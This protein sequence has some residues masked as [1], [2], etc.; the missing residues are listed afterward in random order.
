MGR[1]THDLITAAAL[2]NNSFED[3]TRGLSDPAHA[4]IASP[5][6]SSADL[7][8][9]A[10]RDVFGAG[11]IAPVGRRAAMRI[12]AL[13]RARNLVVSSLAR[14]PLVVMEGDTRASVQPIWTT[15]VPTTS[16]QLRMAWTVD[17]VF[18]Y[19]LSC[20]QRLGDGSP[21]PRIRY[22]D[23]R[24]DEDGR[25]V[26]NDTPM[27]D[28][29]VIT[30]FGFNEG[31]LEHGRDAIS[32]ASML[33][34]AVRKRLLNPVPSIDL[35]QTGGDQ[36]TDTEIDALIDRWAAARQGRNGGVSY[37]NEVIDPREMGT[38]GEQLMIE[39][40]NAA[41]VDMARIANVSA[42]MVDATAP[43][44]SLNYETQEGRSLE[45]HDLDLALY[46]DPIT[47]RLSLDDITPPGTRTAFDFTTDTQVAY[48]PTGAPVAD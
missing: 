30:F 23:W 4:A 19:G 40:R 12:P 45:F 47:A 37:S 2:L 17:D 26:W 32:D 28:D 5:F 7:K 8:A 1:R 31:V 16:P 34:E 9:I 33:Y 43:K 20:W 15:N 36:L 21:G 11:V 41:A 14:V 38:G 27:N 39:G 18:F 10:W 3:V 29:E 13:A 6:G 35:H 42:G 46:A 48:T 44:A 22:D 25:V 24:F